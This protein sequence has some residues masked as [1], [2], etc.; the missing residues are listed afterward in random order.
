MVIAPVVCVQNMYGLATRREDDELITLCAEHGIAF[1]PFFA[2]GGAGAPGADTAAEVAKAHDATPAQ[3][4]LA[5]TLHK[6]QNVL[7]IPGTGDPAHLEEN[8]AA[9]A[10]RLS[11]E[12]LARLD[13][14]G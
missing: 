7:A 6:G 2:I 5:W 10:L 3:V 9:G 1:V 13:T 4:R 11:P 14:I 12:E 8:V